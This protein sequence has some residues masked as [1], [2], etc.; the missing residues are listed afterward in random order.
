MVAPAVPEIQEIEIGEAVSARTAALASFHSLGPPDLVHLT[1]VHARTG[2]KEAST[3]HYV[4]GID[5]SSAS[6]AAYLNTLTYAPG[7]GQIWFGKVQHWD[8]QSGVYCCYNSISRVDLRVRVHIPGSVEAFVIDERGEKHPLT[9]QLM[10]ETYVCSVIRALI[11]AD[12]DDYNITAYRRFNP[13]SSPE[14]EERFLDAASKMFSR[15]WQFGSDVD[16]QVPTL[17]SNNLTTVFFKYL[18]LTGRY[19]QGVNLLEKLRANEPD[20]DALLARAYLDMD[21]EVKAVDF[22]HQSIAASPRD[23]NLLEIQTRFCSTKGRL[24]FALATAKRAVDSAPSEFGPWARLVKVYIEMQDFK[25]ALLTLNSCPMFPYQSVDL[26]RMPVAQRVHLPIAAEGV[27]QDIID[28]AV[29]G[30]GE[31]TTVDPALA[32]LPASSLRGTFSKAYD[33]LVEIVHEIGWDV[34]LKYRSEVFI[35]EEEYRNLKTETSSIKKVS[36]HNR[37]DSNASRV[38][39]NGRPSTVGTPEVAVGEEGENAGTTTVVSADISKPESSID[40][41]IVKGS[42]DHHH[43][44]SL[45]SAADGEAAT[46]VVGTEPST[47]RSKRLCERWLDNL[48]MVMYEDMRVYTLWRAEW[49]H[50]KAQNLA[51]RKSLREWE[52]LGELALRMKHEPESSEAF[53]QALEIRFSARAL[54][55]LLQIYEKH[56]DF[57]NMLHATIKLSSYNHRWYKEYSPMLI[58]AMKKLVYEEGSQKLRNMIQGSDYSSSVVELMDEYFELARTFRWPGYEDDED[59]K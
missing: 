28:D 9:D 21:E 58:L 38:A 32:R 22:L 39:V 5:P 34:L 23:P 56:N 52:I 4:T 35:M 41:E 8:I 29:A 13:I 54:R 59:G 14:E 48:F 6:V 19:T 10:L 37:A 11:Y 30:E 16:V 53:G 2:V 36:N 40:A 3:Y 15:G 17:L 24:D 33:M 51:Y 43:G 47:F 42:E 7:E 27:M 1:K 31:P 20:F 50:Y 55:G 26:H 46:E 45:L 57:I 49:Q 44:S 12:N 25:S 18:E